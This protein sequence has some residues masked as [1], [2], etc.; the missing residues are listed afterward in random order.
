[1]VKAIW[2]RRAIQET[3]AEVAAYHERAMRDEWKEG[4]PAQSWQQFWDEVRGVY[5]SIESKVVRGE[6]S[7]TE[8]K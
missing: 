6:T 8:V 3:L 4:V 7:M 2:K 1:M 5:P